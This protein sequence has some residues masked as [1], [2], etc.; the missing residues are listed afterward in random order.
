MRTSKACEVM[1]LA[2][3]CG[4]GSIGAIPT[5]EVYSFFADRAFSFKHGGY[6]Y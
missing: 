4:K 5:G 6:T 3:R 1:A 2:A